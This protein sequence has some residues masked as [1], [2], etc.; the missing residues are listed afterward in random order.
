M[1]SWKPGSREGLA[2]QHPAWTASWELLYVLLTHRPHLVKL[3]DPGRARDNYACEWDQDLDAN[4]LSMRQGSALPLARGNDP[5]PVINRRIN[6]R[7]NTASPLVRVA[8]MPLV[9][10]TM[11]E[12]LT[13]GSGVWTPHASDSSVPLRVQMLWAMETRV[14]VAGCP[15]LSASATVRGDPTN[16]AT[17]P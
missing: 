13:L 14:K 7:A 16:L 1:V 8:E 5:H 6:N 2:Q 12:A 15:L 17:Q 4:N 9:Q 11:R 10:A 3:W